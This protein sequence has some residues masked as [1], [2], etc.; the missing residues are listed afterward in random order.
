VTTESYGG[1]IVLLTPKTS[2]QIV[3]FAGENVTIPESVGE[4]NF[5]YERKLFL[6]NGMHTT[7]AFM[8]LRKEQPTGSNPEDHTLLTL[9][10][11]DEVLQE[12]IWAWAVARCGML[13]LRHGMDLLHRIYDSED[14]EIVYENLLEFARTALDRFS[15]VEDKTARIL[16]G[17]VTNRWLTRL[18]PVVDEMEDLLHHVDSR[19]IFEYAGLTDEY[20]DT[21]T[22]KLVN[23][24]RRFCHLD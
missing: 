20:V 16:G 2:N 7:L 23:G 13:I 24:T 11:A 4:A 12:E 3:P 17:G 1:S 19:G 6:V 10:S 22:R 8:T 9:A 14:H 5:F 18:K 15:G 21:T